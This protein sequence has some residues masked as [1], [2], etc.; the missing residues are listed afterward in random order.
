MSKKKRTNPEK[1]DANESEELINQLQRLQA[2]FDNYRKRTEQELTLARNKAGDSLIKG[3]LPVVDNLQLAIKHAD[4]GKEELLKGVLLVQEQLLTALQE[5]DVT[6]IPTEGRFNPELHEAMLT[7]DSNKPSGEI[8]DVL[9]RGY[10]RNGRPL[11][12]A[13]VSVSK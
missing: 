6:P 10:T 5:Q 13:K 9:Q 11:R 1:E 2:E 12:A 8:V 7:V 3:I 4:A